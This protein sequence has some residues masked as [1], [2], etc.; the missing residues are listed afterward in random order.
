MDMLITVKSR[1]SLATACTEQG[2]AITPSHRYHSFSVLQSSTE[3]F[4]G[5]TKITITSNIKQVKVTVR[6]LC[7]IQPESYLDRSSTWSLE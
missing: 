2:T 1:K 5:D 7:A 3:K 4:T 6:V